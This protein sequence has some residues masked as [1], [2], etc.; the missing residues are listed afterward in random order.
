MSW[1]FIW[2]KNLLSNI[3]KIINLSITVHLLL[4]NEMTLLKLNFKKSLVV[5]RQS[6]IRNKAVT[7]KNSN[8]LKHMLRAY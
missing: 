6:A 3:F 4:R 2:F 8:N 1:K 7:D 5:Q